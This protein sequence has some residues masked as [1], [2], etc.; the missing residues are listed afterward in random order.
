MNAKHLKGIVCLIKVSL[1]AYRLVSHTMRTNVQSSE[2]LSHY[3]LE[4]STKRVI[5]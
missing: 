1:N 4:I 5:L 2:T 3:I